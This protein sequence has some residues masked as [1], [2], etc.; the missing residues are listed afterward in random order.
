MRGGGEVGALSQ[1]ECSFMTLLYQIVTVLLPT[2]LFSMVTFLLPNVG[3]TVPAHMKEEGEE[4]KLPARWMALES[5]MD[6]MFS[7]KSDVVG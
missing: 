5:L 1:V 3:T 2:N 7:E 4:V 6:G